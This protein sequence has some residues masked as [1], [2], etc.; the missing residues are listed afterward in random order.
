MTRFYPEN[1][2]VEKQ[3]LICGRTFM[4]KKNK[5]YCSDYCQGV[6]KAA[7]I[8]YMKKAS[9]RKKMYA[10]LVNY[11]KENNLKAVLE[12]YKPGKAA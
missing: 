11:V 12:K 2:D 5:F 8:E 4:G 10:R 6:A 9:Q 3:C 1:P 7:N